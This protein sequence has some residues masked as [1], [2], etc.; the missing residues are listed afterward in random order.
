M[1][2]QINIFVDNRTG[3][4]KSITEVLYNENVNIRAMAIQDRGEFGL[5]KL[6]VDKPDQAVI[7]LQGHGFACKE[8]D[9]LAIVLEDKPGGLYQLLS[10]FP[11]ETVNILDAYGFAAETIK[12][13]VFFIEVKDAEQVGVFLSRKGFKVL[14]DKEILEI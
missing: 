2:K 10:S 9:V 11:E 4:I 7:A 1:A 14:T 6:I 5:V 3:R 13:S 12:G 8:K